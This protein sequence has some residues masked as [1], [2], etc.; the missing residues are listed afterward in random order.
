V[1]ELVRRG[2]VVLL[3]TRGR[4]TGRTATAAL[5]FVE[6]PD[7]AVLV[8]AGD[9]NADWVLNLAADPHCSIR[10]ADIASD[11]VAEQLDEAAHHQVVVSLILKYGTPA[12]R[13]GAGP[14]FRLVPGT[15]VP[16]DG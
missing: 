9:T 1:D 3:E 15:S 12:E 10:L 6:A 4:V 8:A 13:L 14:A 2:K 7:G 5:G 11:R 16:H